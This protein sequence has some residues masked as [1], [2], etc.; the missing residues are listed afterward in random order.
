M[1]LSIHNE[2]QVMVLEKVSIIS[3]TKEQNSLFFLY[4]FKKIPFDFEGRERYKLYKLLNTTHLLFFV[5][6]EEKKYF[7]GYITYGK[8][9]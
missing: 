4:T 5:R 6:N 1:I 3:M 8:Q 2:V 7:L 9:T